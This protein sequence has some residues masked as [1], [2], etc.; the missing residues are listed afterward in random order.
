MTRAEEFIKHHGVK[1]MKWGVRKD[2]TTTSTSTKTSKL[3][4]PATDVVVKQKPGQFVR[5]KGGKKQVAA[6]D[7][8]RIAATR[9][10]A[11]RST[12]DSLSTKQLQDAV[13]RMNLEQQYSKLS[14]KSDR[15]TR[16][17]RFVRSLLGSKGDNSTASVVTGVASSVG[18]AM[19]AGAAA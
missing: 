13:N 15:R 8:V 3:R 5:A 18:K 2:G 6:E 10:F 1:G 9:Q 14:K 7:A 16:G 19:A 4:R 11:K 17:Q 12:T